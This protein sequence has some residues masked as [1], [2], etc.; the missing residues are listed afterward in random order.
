MFYW[1]LPDRIT[2]G[3]RECAGGRQSPGFP[4]LERRT[5]LPGAARPS[6]ETMERNRSQG[7]PYG[8]E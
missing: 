8:T 6:T 1:L 4:S 7:G 3:E 2:N 5:F